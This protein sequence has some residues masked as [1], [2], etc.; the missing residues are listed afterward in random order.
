MLKFMILHLEELGELI[1]N[2]NAVVNPDSPK[3]DTPTLIRLNLDLEEILDWNS[4]STSEGHSY[5]TAMIARISEALVRYN[6]DTDDF[7]FLEL[8]NDTGT[9]LLYFGDYT[10]ADLSCVRHR[11][12]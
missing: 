12:A 1:N 5:A 4:T 3:I 10:H 11:I 2:Y 9:L 8:T 7:R 6:I